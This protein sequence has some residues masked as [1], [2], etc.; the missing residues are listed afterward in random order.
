MN[1]FG[2]GIDLRRTSS[3][4]P[5]QYEA[6]FKGK[7]VGYVSFEGGALN[8]T[9]QHSSNYA[10]VWIS[11]EPKGY[12]E[13]EAEERDL[14]LSLAC[15]RLLKNVE[16]VWANVDAFPRDDWKYEVGNGDTILGYWEW[17]ESR[18]RGKVEEDKYTN[19]VTARWAPMWAWDLIDETLEADASSSAFDADLR[20]KIRIAIDGMLM[21]SEETGD[22]KLLSEDDVMDTVNGAIS[23]D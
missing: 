3:R 4:C 19:S 12:D 16:G 23:D 20:K 8:V 18:I 6:I 9:R 2:F 5:E 13:F 22:T 17:V 14:F 21:A 11:V 10:E 1:F 15:M 7:C